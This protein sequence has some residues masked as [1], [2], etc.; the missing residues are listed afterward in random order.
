MGDG[1]KAGLGGMG[2]FV[3]RYLVAFGAASLVRV[4]N[5]LLAVV[6]DASEA[7]ATEGIASWSSA[8]GGFEPHF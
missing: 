8:G 6:A 4:A 3:V 7:F 5:A 2:G 1:V